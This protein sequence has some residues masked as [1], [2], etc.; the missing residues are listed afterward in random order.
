MRQPIDSSQLTPRT[1][2]RELNQFIIGQDEAKKTVAIALRNRMRRRLLDED[3]QEDVI[4]KNIILIGPT[5]VGKTEIARRLARLVKAPLVKVEAT[6]YTEVGYVGRD[7]ESMVRD[8]VGTAMNMVRE[9]MTETVRPQAE[10]RAREQLI[11]QLMPQTAE[12][13]AP[14][15]PLN[16][17]R[18]FIS[19][20]QPGVTIEDDTGDETTPSTREQVARLLDQGRLDDREVEIEVPERPATEGMMGMIGVD[21][22]ML[23]GLRDMME[24]MMPQ[25]SHRTRMTIAQ[26][27]QLLIEQEAEQLLDK[28]KIKREALER[29]EQ[30]GIIFID[31]LDKVAGRQG[32]AGPDVSREGVQR[33]ILPIVE[34]STVFTKHGTIRT[35]HILFIAAGAFHATKPSDL[36]P[37]LQGRFPLR[38]E[39]HSLDVDDF[40]RILVEPRHSLIKQYVAL[41]AT[42]GVKLV[43]T[44]DA[45]EEVARSAA[46]VNKQS[47][48]IGAR[49]LHSIME[50]VL[51]PIAFDSPDQLQGEVTV[52]AEFV[53]QRLHEVLEDQ[54]LS[55]FIL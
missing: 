26:A 43:M 6:K 11:D 48:N 49:R 54:D 20:E 14:G 33:D 4:P 39:L 53:R 18:R 46:R 13:P 17:Q 3:M 15:A 55:R 36:I 41:M 47:E 24:K 1:I 52:D 16:T 22:Q 21:E 19:G 38:V 34:G 9:E 25:K 37:E 51:E 23:S 7:V 31:E 32:G 5:G 35:D 8:L 40:K 45:I 44:E 10:R 27:R 42:D 28:E 12:P 2:V 30:T 29:A 50:R